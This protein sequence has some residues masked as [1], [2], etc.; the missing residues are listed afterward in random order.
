[1]H[2][3]LDGAMVIVHMSMVVA[4]ASLTQDHTLYFTG[5][6]NLT[7]MQ[8]KSST[9]ANRL[10]KRSYAE[11]SRKGA[12]IV[13]ITACAENDQLAHPGK[14]NRTDQTTVDFCSG[15][16]TANMISSGQESPY[17]NSLKFAVFGTIVFTI[18]GRK[19]E[20]T[21][22]RIG[23][24]SYGDDFQ[25]SSGIGILNRRGDGKRFQTRSEFQLTFKS[26]VSDA[27]WWIGSPHCQYNVTGDTQRLDCWSCGVIIFP[28]PVSDHF[29]VMEMHGEQAMNDNVFQDSM[30]RYEL[31]AQPINENLCILNGI[32]IVGFVAEC[33]AFLVYHFQGCRTKTFMKKV[34]VETTD[35]LL[36]S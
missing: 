7:W 17:P 3:C 25:E 8:D 4:V 35:S 29:I 26:D 13:I 6:Q 34:H 21:D 19:H 32:V 24:G 18:R 22:M 10:V 20:C 1:M 12:G 16:G 30:N 27:N 33:L 23:H 14:R 36:A 2:R 28:F 11:K 9:S 31:V 5:A 15:I